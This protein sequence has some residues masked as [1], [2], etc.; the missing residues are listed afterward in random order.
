MN[1]YTF[2]VHPHACTDAEMDMDDRFT[3]GG[4]Q[5]QDEG[6]LVQCLINLLDGEEGTAS[7]PASVLI[8]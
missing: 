8:S 5:E 7:R 3:K 2:A 1:A 6:G 4:R